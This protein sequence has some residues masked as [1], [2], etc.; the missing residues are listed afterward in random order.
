MLTLS[1]NTMPLKYS[2]LTQQYWKEE[3]VNRDFSPDYMSPHFALQGVHDKGF[4][5]EAAAVLNHSVLNFSTRFYRGLIEGH[6]AVR[7]E[8]LQG[9]PELNIT[10]C[11]WRKKQNIIGVKKN[12]WKKKR[13]QGI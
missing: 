8:G 1:L 2:L 4:L 13:Q 7:H 10:F 11:K 5:H 9:I 3:V 12:Q 6:H